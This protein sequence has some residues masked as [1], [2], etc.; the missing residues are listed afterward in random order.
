[1]GQL[2]DNAEII[3]DETQ[4]G[5]NTAQRVGGWM[6]DAAEAIDDNPIIWV[7]QVEFD[8]ENNPQISS[9]ISNKAELQVVITRTAEGAYVFSNPAFTQKTVLLD[10]SILDENLNV[11]FIR[12]SG[13]VDGDLLISSA[14]SLG[15]AADIQ[16]GSLFIKI[17]VYP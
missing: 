13:V 8:G 7:A 4:A 10:F 3:R 12:Y 1:M 5:A 14:N 17:E 15:L 16:I 9:V 2:K 11:L 6:V